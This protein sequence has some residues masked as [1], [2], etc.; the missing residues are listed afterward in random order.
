[1]WHQYFLVSEVLPA[2]M[3]SVCVFYY[4]ERDPIAVNTA[5]GIEDITYGQI[6]V[7]NKATIR[8]TNALLCFHHISV[9]HPDTDALV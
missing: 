3:S 6:I 1:M 5:V 9:L 4:A 8:G 7:K 2:V